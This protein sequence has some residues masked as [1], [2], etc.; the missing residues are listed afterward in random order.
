MPIF[1]YGLSTEAISDPK[2]QIRCQI[3]ETGRRP[4]SRNPANGTPESPIAWIFFS[5]CKNLD[6]RGFKKEGEANRDLLRYKTSK[7]VA[8]HI[9]K[10]K[11]EMG[12]VLFLCFSV[13]DGWQLWFDSS[14]AFFLAYIYAQSSEIHVLFY[15]IG[16]L[17]GQRAVCLVFFF[18]NNNSNRVMWVGQTVL[19]LFLFFSNDHGWVIG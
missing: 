16:G 14:K 10:R 13:M 6:K 12:V 8:L 4:T 1:R 18:I 15:I 5:P 11:G 9:K 7:Q 2:N 19:Y 3:C 17:Q